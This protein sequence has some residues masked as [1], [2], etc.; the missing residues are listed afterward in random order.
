MK[1][2]SNDRNPKISSALGSGLLLFVLLGSIGTLF[3]FIPDPKQPS[4][5]GLVTVWTFS[6]AIAISGIWNKLRPNWWAESISTFSLASL[7]LAAAIHGLVYV[8]S[9]WLWIIPLVLIYLFAWVLPVINPRLAKFLYTEQTAPQTYIGKSCLTVLLS[10]LG[11]AGPLGAVIGLGSSRLYGP[12][13]SMMIL[14]VLAAVLSI[15]FA[16]YFA[17]HLLAKWTRK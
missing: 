1:T 8:L 5:L 2:T 10:A 15:G 11:I 13:L 17:Y 7:F 16:Q 6:L 4:I 9:N 3:A 12:G 14:G